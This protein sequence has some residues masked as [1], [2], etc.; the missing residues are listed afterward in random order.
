MLTMLL[1][2]HS[3]PFCLYLALDD[4]VDVVIARPK[5]DVF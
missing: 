2:M 1:L 3:K 4:C 5:A